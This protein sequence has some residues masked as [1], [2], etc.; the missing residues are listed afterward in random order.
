MKRSV[1]AGCIV[2]SA[3]LLVAA[4]RSGTN[5]AAGAANT[6]DA[7]ETAAASTS[8]PSASASATANAAAATPAA[9]TFKLSGRVTGSSGKNNLYVALWQADGF[10][11]HPVQQHK[12]AAGADPVFEFEVP[13]GRWALSSFEDRNGNGVLDVGMFGPKEPSGFWRPFNGHHKPR[14]DEVASQIDKDISNIEIMLK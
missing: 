2:V 9:E 12:V 3:V 1:W 5:A 4:I 7:S 14:F 8:A 10:L 6:G 11:H 13:A